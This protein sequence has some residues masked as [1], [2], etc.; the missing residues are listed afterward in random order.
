MHSNFIKAIRSD[1]RINQNKFFY[2]PRDPKA[3][4]LQI[5]Q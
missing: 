2:P 1:I 4:H 3:F 5:N